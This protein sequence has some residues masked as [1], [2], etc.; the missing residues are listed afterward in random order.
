MRNMARKRLQMEMDLRR[1]IESDQLEL[2][3]QPIVS[4]RNG[5]IKGLEALARWNHPEL[6]QI[7]PLEFIPVASYNFV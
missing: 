3:Y 7:S 1:A 4:L 6:G 2:Y 5:Q